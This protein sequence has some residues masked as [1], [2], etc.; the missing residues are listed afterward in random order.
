MDVLDSKESGEKYRLQVDGLGYDVELPYVLVPAAEGSIRIASFN[1]IGQTRL[2]ADLGRLLA[3][4]I[5]HEVADYQSVMV[6]TAVEKAL[7]LT[8]VVSSELGIEAVAVA[9]NRIKPHMEVERRPVIQVGADSITSGDKFL[10]L[11]ERDMQLL[12]SAQNGYII[13]D[14]VVSTGGTV[15][16]L[17]EILE[18]AAARAGLDLPTV[19]GIF[20]AATEGE[21]GVR[22]PAPVRSLARLPVPQ[23]V[24]P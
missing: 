23:T 2:N 1:L 10:A 19:H 7:Q 12:A 8:Q 22:L 4:K 9:Y 21:S 14:D 16:G 5:R 20:C 17:Y 24:M 11:Y 6:L 18:E 3:A 13:I 15:L